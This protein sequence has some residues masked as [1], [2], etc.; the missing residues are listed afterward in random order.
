MQKKR[1]AIFTYFMQGGGLE[2]VLLNLMQGF[3]ARDYEVDL[4]LSVAEG[5]FM[6]LIPD[7]VRVINIDTPRIRTNITSLI[8]YLRR[9]KPEILYC[10]ESDR[11]FE[12]VVAGLLSL[13]RTRVMIGMHTVEASERP[14][15]M[16]KR[17]KQYLQAQRLVCRLAS[18]VIPVSHGLVDEIAEDLHIPKRKMH[19]I[20]NPI[21]NEQMKQEMQ[22]PVEHPWLQQKTMPVVLAVGRLSHVKGFDVLIKAFKHVT[23]QMEA[24]LIILGEPAFYESEQGEI[25]TSLVR[26]LGL[27]DYVDLPGF[28]DNPY[29]YMK[30]ADLF[31]S[32]SRYEGFGNV[33]VEALACGCPVVSTDCP[34]GPIEI[35]QNGEYGTLVPVDDAEALGQ[36]IVEALHQAHDI[37][38]LEKRATDFS[39]DKIIEE[40]VELFKLK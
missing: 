30:N 27:E 16:G 21:V 35:L 6:K 18:K 36:A 34:T 31:V 38:K 2:R 14:A 20:H 28:A 11:G 25:H 4:L 10:A 33:I 8:Q 5:P 23:S 13:T 12:G 29:A 39:V 24:R 7:G 40:Y 17:D 15:N 1:I 22:E 37:S 26:E 3:I 19:V 32:S 9:E